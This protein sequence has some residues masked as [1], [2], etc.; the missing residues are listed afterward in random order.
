MYV[1]G[2]FAGMGYETV[3]VIGYPHGRR[4]PV[5]A[6]LPP[7]Y[8][9]GFRVE[10][11]Y[12]SVILRRIHQGEVES[13]SACGRFR[14]SAAQD[15]TSEQYATHLRHLATRFQESSTKTNP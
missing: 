12:R 8:L 14:V 15:V 13:P 6:H 3:T 9:G 11:V 4:G 7:V 2:G 10:L 1:V 5:L